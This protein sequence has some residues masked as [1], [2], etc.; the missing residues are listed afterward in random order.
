MYL[1]IRNTQSLRSN[2]LL[3]VPPSL[4]NNIHVMDIDSPTAIR[5][6]WNLT[7]QTLDEAADDIT[8]V[9]T[10]R[11]ESAAAGTHVVSGGSTS[12]D[13]PVIP[14]Q[15]YFLKLVARNQDG[16]R[17]ASQIP[18]FTSPAGKDH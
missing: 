18:F 8:L 16:T 1:Q 3:S 2:L 6:K 7:N 15:E 14:D 10:L 5:V 17:E 13:V 12:A 11:G 4:P 9:V